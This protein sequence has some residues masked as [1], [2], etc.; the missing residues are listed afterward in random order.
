MTAKQAQ[1]LVDLL[2][3]RSP[4]YQQR[5]NALPPPQPSAVPAAALRAIAAS[6]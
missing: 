1:A 3:K 6:Q 5:L 4:L 2:A